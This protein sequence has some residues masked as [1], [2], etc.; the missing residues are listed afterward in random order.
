MVSPQSLNV[1]SVGIFLC[2]WY[3]SYCILT[4]NAPWLPISISIGPILL[5]ISLGQELQS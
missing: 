5:H 1:L 2:Y 4:E 3:I